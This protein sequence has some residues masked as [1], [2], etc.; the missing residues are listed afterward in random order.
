MIRHSVLIT[1]R[2]RHAYLRLCLWSIAR[3]ARACGISDYEVVIVDNGSIYPPFF[4]GAGVPRLH[5]V[6]DR[7]PMPI[8]NKPA[9]WRLAIDAAAGELLTF[10]DADA[11]VGRDWMAGLE[12]LADPAI[13]R[14]CYRVR[15]LPATV[16]AELSP[17]ANPT[18]A[19]LVDGYFARFDE[20]PVAYEA[21]GSS[22]RPA[23]NV[24]LAGFRAP[25]KK[26]PWG[27]SQF[28][29][30]RAAL[31]DLRPDPAYVGHGFE[32]LDFLRQF[33]RH[34][35]DSYRGVIHTDAARAMFH[36]QHDYRNDWHTHP[37][38]DANCRRYKES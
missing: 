8:F 19:K 7:S 37:L 34:Y 15:Y 32:D 38:I 4:V 36:L 20:Y 25:P 9:L 26:E 5:L 10:L 6:V 23:S 28:S 30:T 35:G 12:V 17:A 24:G 3:S 13:I 1:H 14:L 21:Y 2:D 33:E 22:G 16:A 31:G 18:R 27:N 11:L 29:V